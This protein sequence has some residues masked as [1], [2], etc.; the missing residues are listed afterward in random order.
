MTIPKTG[1]PWFRCPYIINNV[2]SDNPNLP[3]SD[4]SVFWAF[5]FLSC[6]FS[7]R[8][9]SKFSSYFTS[10]FPSSRWPLHVYCAE[11]PTAHIVT[12]FSTRCVILSPA[13]ARNCTTHHGMA[14]IDSLKVSFYYQLDTI[15]LKWTSRNLDNRHTESSQSTENQH[16]QQQ[17]TENNNP[18]T[19]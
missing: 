6:A 7:F 9:P 11:K 10:S 15:W 5:S 12:P 3:Q 19:K 4:P 16:P 2:V 18:E 8:F 17:F 14:H 1:H 13:C